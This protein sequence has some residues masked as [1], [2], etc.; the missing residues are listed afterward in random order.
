MTNVIPNVAAF[1]VIYNDERY[2]ATSYVTWT[3]MELLGINI[4]NPDTFSHIKYALHKSKQWEYEQEWRL[5]DCTIRKNIMQEEVTAVNL[6]PTA[7][8]YGQNIS[9]EN[10]GRLHQ[11][12]VQKGIREYCMYID[13]S[14]PKYEMLFI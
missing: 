4:P 7:I 1:P 3:Y 2:D 9:K 11:I 12:A 5:I 14:S 6:A 10:K 8:Y 13:A